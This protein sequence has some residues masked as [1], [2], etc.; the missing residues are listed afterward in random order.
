[1]Q[2]AGESSFCLTQNVTY[3][4]RVYDPDTLNWCPVPGGGADA[5]LFAGLAVFCSCALY[6]KLS[7]VWVLLAG[8]LFQ[9]AN[10]YFNMN[11]FSNALTIWLGMHPSTIFFQI[12]LPPLLLDSA[13]RVDFFLFKKM[14][15]HCLIFASLNVL[16]STVAFIPLML[17]GLDLA[18]AGWR[19]ID[20]ALF[21]A[22]LGSTDAVAVTAILKAGGAPEMLSTLLEGE[23]LFNDASSI[24]LF[25]IFLHMNMAADKNSTMTH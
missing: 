8:A 24:V 1:M 5:L 9:V 17:Y 25:E 4:H 13:V 18:A 2:L 6:S 14:A 23:S 22:I 11:H 7:A 19:P 15:A 21:G 20:A 3:E 10:V 12:F 16:V